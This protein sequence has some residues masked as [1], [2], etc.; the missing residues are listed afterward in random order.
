MSGFFCA[1]AIKKPDPSTEPGLC[2]KQIK[3]YLI[4]VKATLAPMPKNAA[5]IT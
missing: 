4:L 2:I 1:I 5:A 3:N